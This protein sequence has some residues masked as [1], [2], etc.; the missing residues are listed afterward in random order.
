[1]CVCVCVNNSR[2]K[3]V[4]FQK[5]DSSASMRKPSPVPVRSNQ[6]IDVCDKLLIFVL[7]ISTISTRYW[8][9]LVADRSPFST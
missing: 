8:C 4:L 3:F 7:P 5:Y 6:K 2:F 9:W 1:M